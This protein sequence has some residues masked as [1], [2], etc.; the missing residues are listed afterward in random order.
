MCGGCELEPVATAAEQKKRDE[1]LDSKNR[2]YVELRT[3]KTK[4]QLLANLIG[5]DQIDEERPNALLMIQALHLVLHHD[6]NK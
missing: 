3:M 5:E 1:F 6:A 4:E 2:K